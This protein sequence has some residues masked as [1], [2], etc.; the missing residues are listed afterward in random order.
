[1]VIEQ[2]YKE[3]IEMPEL[4]QQKEKL[5]QLRNFYKPI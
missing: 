3:E 2:K 4:D 1:M 5:K